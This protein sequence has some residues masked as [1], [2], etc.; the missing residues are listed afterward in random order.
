[1][2]SLPVIK[3]RE[4]MN[5]LLRGGFYL[6]HQTGSHA[7]L[8]HKTMPDLKVTVPIHPKDIPKGTLRRIIKQAGLTVGEF[9][10]LLD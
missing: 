4:A 7:R 8:V 2:D 10:Q 5:A 6:H 3:P 1:M 9:L